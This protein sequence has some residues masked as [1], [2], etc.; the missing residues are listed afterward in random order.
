[1][2]IQVI[3]QL[4]ASLGFPIVAC[5]A[6]FWFVNKQDERHRDEMDGL[7]KTLEDN[8]S[9]LTS[10]KELIQILVNKESKQ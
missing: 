6:L 3:S 10:L 4:V 7:R 1:M 5:G 2:D 9:V 8:T